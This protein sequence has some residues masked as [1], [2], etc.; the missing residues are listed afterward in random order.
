MIVAS[1]IFLRQQTLASPRSA[2]KH[3]K[4]LKPLWE[5]TGQLLFMASLG[6]RV[7]EKPSCRSLIELSFNLKQH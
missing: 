1:I 2:T 5:A 4:R 3:D 7:R 6:L